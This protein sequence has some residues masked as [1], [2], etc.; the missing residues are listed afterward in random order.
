ME[1][2]YGALRDPVVILS[3]TGSGVRVT[4]ANRSFLS[5]TGYGK[6]EILGN[7][8]G[9]LANAE[10]PRRSLAALSRAIKLGRPAL[11][12]LAVNRKAG[13]P[14]WAEVSLS[15]VPVEGEPGA[16]LAI[17]RDISDRKRAEKSF[18]ENEQRFGDFL[19]AAA[20][21]YWET[22]AEG[23]IVLH[24]PCGGQA[25]QR[26]DVRLVGK[27]REDIATDT[28]DTAKWMAYRA[29]IAAR[30]PIDNFQYALYEPDGSTGYRKIS[31]APRYGGSGDFAGYRGV[32]WDVSQE[33]RENQ[34]ALA[35]KTLFHEAINRLN[36]G[37]ALFGADNRLIFC[38]Q[39]YRRYQPRGDDL[40]HP[41]ADL[42]AIVRAEISAGLAPDAIGREED[43]VRARTEP[44]RTPWESTRMRWNGGKRF[45]VH[46]HRMSDG[47]LIV[48]V[49]DVT[50]RGE[51]AMGSLAFEQEQ[52]QR[53]AD[54]MPLQLA[55][56]G[57]ELEF[58]WANRRYA[59]WAGMPR[60]AIIGRPMRDVIGDEAYVAQIPFRT[61]AL[62]GETV[63]FDFDTTN[64]Q[65]EELYMRVAMIPNMQSAA[66][67]TG[68]IIAA[69]DITD[70]KQ[71]KVAL[72][73]MKDQAERANDAKSEYLANISHELRTPLNAILGFSE[74]MRDER[75]GPVENERYREYVS[76]IHDSGAHLLDIIDEL[77]DLSRLEAGRVELNEST[78]P[79]RPLL[80]YCFS[81]VRE[82][83][84]D[85]GVILEL[86]AAADLPNLIGDETKIRQIVLNLLSNAIKF[87]DPGEKVRVTAGRSRS[88]DLIVKVRDK[89]PGIAR[90][91]MTLV[92]A[93]FGQG[94]TPAQKNKKGAGLGLSI[95]RKLAELHGGGLELESR[96]GAGTTAT[97][98][99]PAARLSR[100]AASAGP[101]GPGAP[102]SFPPT[103][104]RTGPLPRPAL[105]RQR[106]VWV[107]GGGS[108]PAPS[109]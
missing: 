87:S 28:H 37:I 72:E 2:V 94:R 68:L 38:N 93:P 100:D 19:A 14:F 83:A 20:D 67:P 103:R 25:A 21:W 90:E 70:V 3:A 15:P 56:V 89:G 65:G 30:R 26:E 105:Q 75:L 57:T 88:G 55:Y 98:R 101:A 107:A 61:R 96:L 108:G 64:R 84:R 27:H 63:I 12:E 50:G 11:A 59:E 29:A 86:G 80:E 95:A 99:L 44:R 60:E 23:R 78:F 8:T 92:L 10:T 71:A 16:F 22:D 66:G 13:E 73:E 17:L 91:D 51:A 39:R 35:S 32:C 54:A 58:R 53:I 82:Q 97:I 40:V 33:V 46:E 77:L 104:N 4:Y 74:I 5:A 9:I 109:K 7:P 1:Q 31:G 24:A 62:A 43:W 41:G 106:T 79:V 47:N 85:A 52:F 76:D 45:Q 49:T 102:E 81:L 48:I 69:Q 6:R 42:E 18:R 36:E 34:G